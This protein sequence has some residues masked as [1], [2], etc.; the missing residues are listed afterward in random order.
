M[1]ATLELAGIDK[2]FPGVR[3]L[4]G[5]SVRLRAGSIHALLGE[6]GAGKSTL[7]KVITGVHPPDA[8]DHAHRRRGGPRSPAR[9]RP[10]PP[11][12]AWCTRSAT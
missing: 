1:T 12:S 5:V 9:P 11:A 8:G 10:S 7:I 6:N 4:H 2:S 3:A